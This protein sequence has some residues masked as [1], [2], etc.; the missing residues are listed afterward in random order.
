MMMKFDILTWINYFVGAFACCMG[1][2]YTS[3]ILLE[4]DLSK[5]KIYKYLL[6]FV[7]TIFY[8]INSLAIGLRENSENS[9]GDIATIKAK[10]ISSL[11]AVFFFSI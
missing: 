2:L 6:V 3:K 10:S 8:I 9:S 11:F 5:I 4:V 1:I 7:F